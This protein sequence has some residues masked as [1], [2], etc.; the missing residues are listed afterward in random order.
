MLLEE[1]GREVKGYLSL[2]RESPDGVVGPDR[3]D[4]GQG[5]EGARRDAGRR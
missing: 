5:V 1:E 2:Y 3:A 4:P